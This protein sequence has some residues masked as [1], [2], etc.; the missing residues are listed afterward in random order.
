[1]NTGLC[2]LWKNNRNEKYKKELNYINAVSKKDYEKI[3]KSIINNVFINNV[4]ITGGATYYEHV[5]YKT[6]SWAKSKK[7]LGTKHRI[8]L[9]G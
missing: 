1:M 7:F 3:I 4:D 5:N 8:N 6:P 2:A 9:W